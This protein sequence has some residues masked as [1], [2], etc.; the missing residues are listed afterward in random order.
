MLNFESEYNKEIMIFK[1]NNRFFAKKNNM[2]T[3]MYNK[4]SR[5][6]MDLDSNMVMWYLI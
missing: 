6:L 3:E 2:V 1:T 4:L 5:L